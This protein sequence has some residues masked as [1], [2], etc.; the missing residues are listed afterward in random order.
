MQIYI[1]AY[2]VPTVCS[3]ISNQVLALA[4]D[5]YPHLKGLQLADFQPGDES[6]IEKPSE[7]LFG[8]DMFWLFVED[9]VIRGN[10]AKG[11]VAMKTKLGYIVSGPVYVDEHPLLPDNY[12]VAKSRLNS[13]LYRLKA[14][15]KLAAE[16]DNVIKDQLEKEIVEKVD[17]NEPTEVGKVLYLPHKMVIREDK[18]TT[19]FRVVFVASAKKEGPSLNECLNAGPALL[20]FAYFSRYLDAFSSE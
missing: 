12:T 10:E 11:P 16:Y 2:V 7:I 15:P 5:K 19:K 1:S 3:P 6:E 14:Y 17:L 13:L 18:D 20:S 4:V 8:N 9:E